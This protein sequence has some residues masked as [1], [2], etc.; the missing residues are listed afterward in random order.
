M[1]TDL[2]KRASFINHYGSDS[3]KLRR[4]EKPIE[5]QMSSLIIRISQTINIFFA[6]LSFRRSRLLCILSNSHT[7]TVS[8]LIWRT[9]FLTAMIPSIPNPHDS[10][11]KHARKVEP[12]LAIY[13]FYFTFIL[14]TVPILTPN[15]FEVFSFVKNEKAIGFI[16][17]ALI[18]WKR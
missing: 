5:G 10:S 12:N 16:W 3:A 17:S 1:H 7:T 13:P 9:S 14:T 6:D 15:R 4:N 8:Y 2:L 18:G 11:V